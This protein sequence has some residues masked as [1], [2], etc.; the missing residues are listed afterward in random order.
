MGHILTRQMGI[1]MTYQLQTVLGV[2]SVGD[3]RDIFDK[4]NHLLDNEGRNPKVFE[5]MEKA[6]EPDQY[7]ADQVSLYV[8]ANAGYS[9]QAFVDLLDRLQKTNGKTGNRATDFFGMTTPD[10][11]RLRLIE[12]SLETLPASC[13]LAI[14]TSASQ[15]FRDWQSNSIAFSAFDQT[16]SLF[17]LIGKQKL[18]P[19]LRA[20]ITNLKF[21]PNGQ[22]LLAQDDASVIVMLRT[23]FVPLFRLD[24]TEADPAQFTPDSQGIVFVT[25]GLRVE[26]WSIPK[27]RRLSAQ[28]ITVQNHCDSDVLAPDGKTL[29]CL[30]SNRVDTGGWTF[31][32]SLID[33]ATDKM[34]Y[35]KDKAFA[36]VDPYRVFEFLLLSVESGTR[37]TLVDMHFSQDAHYFVAAGL[38]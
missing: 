29:A 18:D 9:P 33:V 25:S 11:K 34:M 27:Q 24:A 3:R 15:R 10:Q 36:I 23:P 21:S 31:N 30:A 2:N 6:E 16:E 35:E 13:R 7:Q 8:G 19:P 38:D 37:A 20:D 17:G 1:E 32:L 12:Q 5:K 28:E 14:P 26:S 4:V 22:Y